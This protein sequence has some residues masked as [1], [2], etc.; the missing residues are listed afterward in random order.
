MKTAKI[1]SYLFVP[2]VMNVILFLFYAYRFGKQTD[3]FGTELTIALTFGL[4]LPIIVFVILRK[5]GKIVNDDAT[6]KEERTIP[7]IIGVIFC[8]IAAYLTYKTGSQKTVYMMW[9]IY[10]VNS[11]VLIIINHYWKISAHLLGASMPFAGIFYFAANVIYIFIPL[12]LVIGWA[13]KKLQ[14]HTIPQIIA[15]AVLGFALTYLELVWL[16]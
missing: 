10:A 15:G 8:V 5:K 7:Y 6:I 3:T 11:I 14:V 13:R 2:P 12:L 9:L 16:I 1:I 4:I